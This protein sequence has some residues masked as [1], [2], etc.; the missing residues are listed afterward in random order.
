MTVEARRG[1]LYHYAARRVGRRVVKEYLG[2]LTACGAELV[3]LQ[4]EAASDRARMVR[5]ERAAAAAEAAAVLAA[6]DGFD[7]LADRVFRA[8]MHLTGH[9]CHRR[10]EWRRTRRLTPVATLADLFNPAGPKK[11][12][13][14]LC[15]VV[16]RDPNEQKLLDRAAAGDRSVLPAVR[17]LMKEPRW[18]ESCG[19]VELMAKAS[20]IA[21]AAGDHLAVQEAVAEKLDRHVRDLLAGD[22]DPAPLPVR[23][24]ATRAA[25]CWLAVHTLETM[26]T[27]WKAGSATALGVERQLA[28]AE[29][30]LHAALKS[31]ATL[32]RLYRPAVAAQVNVAHGPMLVDNR[33]SAG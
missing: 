4:V 22:P 32:R 8:V 1:R 26:V 14:S 2:P 29:R 20:L 33:G 18:L 19:S 7:R 10:G 24:A 31:L 27:R 9:R 15:R 3:R 25:H 16:T 12:A 28:S 21:E 17:A 23:M 30:R 11:P 5:I 6:A 13:P